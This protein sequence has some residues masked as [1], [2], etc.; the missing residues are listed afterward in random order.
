MLLMFVSGF[1]ARLYRHIN[2]KLTH[3]HFYQTLKFTNMNKP[4]L[5]AEQ[6]AENKRVANERKALKEAERKEAQAKQAELLK[7]EK[8]EAQKAEAKQRR[9]DADVLE[10][11]L[12]EVAKTQTVNS[13][14]LLNADNLEQDEKV[15]V[16]F[17]V[18]QVGKNPFNFEFSNTAKL[19]DVTLTGI[20]HKTGFAIAGHLTG[21]AEKAIANKEKY[22][23]Y[24]TAFNPKAVFKIEVY[25][26]AK[27]CFYALNSKGLDA[28]RLVDSKGLVNRSL[29]VDKFEQ[30]AEQ[31]QAIANFT[32]DLQF[33]DEVENMVKNAT[34]EATEATI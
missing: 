16:R 22:G 28:I 11:N 29:L 26:N 13:P 6:K 19:G 4:V 25:I 2:F 27:I 17:V 32:K 12:I 10:R 14:L 1:G 23:K 8:K 5:T 30:I 20:A 31:V 34:N 7:A 33:V 18:T 15:N 9:I 21:L 24:I 3:T